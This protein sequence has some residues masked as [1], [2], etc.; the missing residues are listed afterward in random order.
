ME[1]AKGRYIFINFEINYPT[2]HF[3]CVEIEARKKY[4]TIFPTEFGPDVI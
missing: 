4:S 1:Y 2:S 3:I